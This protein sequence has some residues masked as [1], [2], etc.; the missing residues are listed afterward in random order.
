LPTLLPVESPFR[1]V[2]VEQ[3]RQIFAALRVALGQVAARPYATEVAVQVLRDTINDR[4]VA[5]PVAVKFPQSL[6]GPEGKTN[7]AEVEAI[8]RLTSLPT[9]EER[10]VVPL[11]RDTAVESMFPVLDPVSRDYPTY[12][13]AVGVGFHTNPHRG[14]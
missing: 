6:N 11:E 12:K 10:F 4:V 7:G 13:G 9:F 5:H 1:A 3:H 2:A 8:F 14:P